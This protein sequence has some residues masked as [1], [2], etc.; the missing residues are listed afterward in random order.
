VEDVCNAFVAVLKAPREVIHAQAFNVG[1]D[2]ENYRIRTV[3][4]I[5]S[6][7]VDDSAINFAEG[8]GGDPRCYRV[9]FSKIHQSLPEYTPSWDVERGV[10]QLRDAFVAVGMTREDLEGDRYQRIRTILRLLKEER[11]DTELRWLA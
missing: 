2:G 1:R 9:D 6:R 11:L 4:E 10:T 7:L 5:V 8:A 3:A